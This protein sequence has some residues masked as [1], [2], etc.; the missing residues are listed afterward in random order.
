MA[1]KGKE[2]H[3]TGYAIALMIVSEEGNLHDVFADY[4]LVK[5]HTRE[6]L[7]GQIYDETFIN[8]LGLSKAEI[9]EHCTGAE[10]HGAYFHLNRPDYLA[11]RIVDQAK[12]THV[13]RS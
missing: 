6:A 10:F 8:K 1:D 4:F 2:L 9:R 11:K 7:M 13:T 12:G 5:G 3:R